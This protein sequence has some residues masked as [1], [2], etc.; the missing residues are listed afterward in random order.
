ML[1]TI[2]DFQQLAASTLPPPVLAYFE[3]GAD[4]E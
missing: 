1:L 3:N 2:R 4:D